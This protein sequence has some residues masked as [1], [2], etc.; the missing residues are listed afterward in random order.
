MNKRLF[1]Y[2]PIHKTLIKMKN[3]PSIRGISEA[4]EFAVPQIIVRS[5]A[6]EIFRTDI[7]VSCVVW[8]L[9]KFLNCLYNTNAKG[10]RTRNIIWFGKKLLSISKKLSKLFDDEHRW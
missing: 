3:R 4:I 10:E 8:A 6:I 1:I 7:V 9:A 2:N 5:I